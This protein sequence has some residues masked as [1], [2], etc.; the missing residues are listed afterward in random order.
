[1]KT[2]NILTASFLGLMS[3][4]TFAATVDGSITAS[5]YQWNTNGVEG[6]AKWNTHGGTQELNDAS[7]G[8]VYDINFLGTNVAGGKFQFGAVGGSILS[9][10]QAGSGGGSPIFLSDFA[11]SVTNSTSA[12]PTTSS[13]GFEFAIHLVGVNDTT[14]IADFQLLSGGTWVGADIYGSAHG[15]DHITETYRMLGGTVLTSFQGVWTA[16]GGDDNVLEGEFNLSDLGL[17]SGSGAI[18]STYLTMA[19]VNDEALVHADLAAVPV[20]AA[21][22]LFAPALIGFMGLRRRTTTTA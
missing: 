10:L 13:A 22:W 17:L 18:I 11:I 9:G 20:P 6:S 1:M 14:G 3:L 21:L 12:N 2:L 7:G 4:S 5:E 16:N 19:C 15:T 8:D